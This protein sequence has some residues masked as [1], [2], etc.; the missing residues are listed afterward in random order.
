MCNSKEESRS[1]TKNQGRK[2]NDP[3]NSQMTSYKKETTLSSENQ[4]RHCFNILIQPHL[5]GY[6]DEKRLSPLF[7]K[8]T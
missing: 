3:C 1:W 7:R 2:L 8:G 4:D 6:K 5:N